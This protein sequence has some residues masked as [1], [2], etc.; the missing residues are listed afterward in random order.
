MSL[1]KPP[2]QIVF[3]LWETLTLPFPIFA[4]HSDKAA[5][6]SKC[7]NFTLTFKDELLFSD[8]F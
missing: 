5:W 8:L 2:Y 1:W 6:S 4:K 3:D 7:Q